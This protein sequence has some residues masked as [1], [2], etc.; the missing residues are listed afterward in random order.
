MNWNSKHFK[1][2]ELLSPDG[3]IM[4]AQ[5]ENPVSHLLIEKLDELRELVKRPVL[6]N[7]AGLQLRGYRSEREN[8]AI[9][10]SA[11]HSYHMRGLAADVTIPGMHPG[12]VATAALDVGF[13]GIGIYR[14]WTHVDC[15]AMR[16]SWYSA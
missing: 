15:R 16:A 6:V 3:L 2:H 1:P 12:D 13:T 11:K 8:A 9:K 10:N 7:Y 5:G 14:T 4:L